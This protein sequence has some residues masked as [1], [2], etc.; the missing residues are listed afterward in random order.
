MFW[1]EDDEDASGLQAVENA[2]R[3]YYSKYD[4]VPTLVEL[5]PEWEQNANA[6]EEQLDGLRVL[7][8]K[9]IPPRTVAVAHEE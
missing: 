9:M 1:F 2:V 5:P 4:H 8:S 7:V 6:I 3:H